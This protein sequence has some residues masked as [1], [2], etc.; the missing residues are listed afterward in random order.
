MGGLALAGAISGMGQGLE[1][2]LSQLQ[3]GIIQQGLLEASQEFQERKL[4][5]QLDHVDKRAER[6]IAARGAEADKSRA[7]AETMQKQGFTHAEGETAKQIGSHEKIAKD[8][9]LSHKEISA[10]NND[11]Q[12]KIA[13]LKD[14]TDIKQATAGELAAVSK[15]L[16]DKRMDLRALRRDLLA[17][18]KEMLD[19]M[20][21]D[22]ARKQQNNAIVQ[23]LT[24]DITA[25]EQEIERMEAAVNT[26]LG[27]APSSAVTRPSKKEPA[28]WKSPTSAA[29]A[30]ARRSG[31][32]VTVPEPPL[33]VNQGMIDSVR[34]LKEM[35][36]P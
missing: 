6:D 10:A 12:L 21:N 34:R 36:K 1:R 17:F 35:Q 3:G 4:R 18:E 8:N 29:Q 26:R 15:V 27:I 30:P 5:E 20:K 13:R 33:G 19:P 7:H 31:G 2:G 23:S 32:M 24:D 22:P 9:N 28:P 11:I 16:G 14:T 25:S